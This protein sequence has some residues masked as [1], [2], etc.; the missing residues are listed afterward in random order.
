MVT[1]PGGQRFGV[2]HALAVSALLHALLFWPSSPH[3]HTASPRMPLMAK[4]QALP[5]VVP[6]PSPPQVPRHPGSNARQPATEVPPMPSAQALP[7]TASAETQVAK[8]PEAQHSSARMDLQK[9][10]IAPAGEELDGEGLRSYRIALAREARRYKRYPP[11]A[12]EG[13]WMGTSELRITIQAGAAQTVN[14]TKSSG[15]AVLDA[16]ALDMLHRAL[17]GAPLPPTLLGR[18]F[19]IDLPVVFELPD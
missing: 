18:S 13:G 2:P 19:V 6:A 10:A 15:Y 17:P 3:R 11:L 8:H 7:W 12:I 5:A 16:A 1:D 9:A 4:L 14:L